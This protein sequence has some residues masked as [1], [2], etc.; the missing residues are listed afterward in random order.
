MPVNLTRGWSAASLVPNIAQAPVASPVAANTPMSSIM[1]SI[2]QSILGA[3]GGGTTSQPQSTQ[4]Q[5]IAASGYAGNLA[6]KAQAATSPLAIYAQLFGKSIGDPGGLI[7]LTSRDPRIMQNLA[8]SGLI[9]G[10][11]PNQSASVWGAPTLTGAESTIAQQYD[12]AKSTLTEPNNAL[13]RAATAAAGSP[14]YAPG[15]M[16]STTPNVNTGF[17]YMPYGQSGWVSPF[18][19]GNSVGVGTTGL[20]P[21]FGP[22]GLAGQMMGLGV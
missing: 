2:L 20:N 17:N 21:V 16:Q 9:S 5:N 10:F 22:A 19:P 11:T 4:A 12:L 18:R 14:T 15:L 8:T 13:S 6:A 3:G 7:G 1:Q